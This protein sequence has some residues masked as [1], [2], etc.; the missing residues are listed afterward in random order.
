MREATELLTS[1]SDFVLAVGHRPQLDRSREGACCQKLG[2]GGEATLG[3][4]TIITHLGT[5]IAVG[6]RDEHWTRSAY[7]EVFEQILPQCFAV[8]NRPLQIEGLLL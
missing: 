2:V 5:V 7:L 1:Q 4:G 3:Q 6:L 8:G